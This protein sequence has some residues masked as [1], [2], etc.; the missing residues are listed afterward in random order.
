MVP[1]EDCRNTPETG[2]RDRSRNDD[3]TAERR[4]LQRS[5]DCYR[6]DVLVAD[7]ELDGGVTH[8][9]LVATGVTAE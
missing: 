6:T 1:I 2:M 9:A 8:A 3:R 4:C 7:G 5:G